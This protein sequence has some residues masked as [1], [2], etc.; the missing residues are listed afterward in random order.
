MTK[1]EA[2]IEKL[3]KIRKVSM[4]IIQWLIPREGIKYVDAFPTAL[5]ITKRHDPT[6][7]DEEAER[8]ARKALLSGFSCADIARKTGR[9]RIT[10]MQCAMRRA[11]KDLEK[12]RKVSMSQ[13]ARQREFNE[14]AIKAEQ[15]KAA[16]LRVKLEKNEARLST[17][18]ARVADNPEITKK[19]KRRDF[20]YSEVWR[21]LRFK[22]LKKSSGCCCLCG[23]GPEPGKPLH[24]DHI[25][26]R[27][28]YPHL[29][30]EENNLQVLCYDCNLGKGNTDDTDWREPRSARSPIV[31]QPYTS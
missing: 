11:V 21:A 18:L 26:P 15:K 6:L 22:V 16:K 19:G 9:M 25:K 13:E 4:E 20:Y 8:L 27:S 2:A 5:M 30:L 23:N 10:G 29:E 3:A 14:K 7:S 31:P 17:L 1:A 28:L 24:V 12:E